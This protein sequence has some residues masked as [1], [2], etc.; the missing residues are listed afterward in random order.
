MQWESSHFLLP[1][2]SMLWWCQRLQRQG[3][4]WLFSKSEGRLDQIRVEQ[5]ILFCQLHS[6]HIEQVSYNLL[7]PLYDFQYGIENWL[8]V[9]IGGVSLD[10]IHNQTRNGS[11]FHDSIPKQNNGKK[12]WCWYMLLLY[13]WKWRRWR[14]RHANR[15][16]LLHVSAQS[17]LMINSS[18]N[19]Y[20]H[21]VEPKRR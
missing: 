5:V 19:T 10:S 9:G 18:I 21:E 11:M 3:I 7:L 2:I 15:I 6:D 4:D 17:M 16:Q 13:V 8:V 1:L 14:E 12:N 20:I